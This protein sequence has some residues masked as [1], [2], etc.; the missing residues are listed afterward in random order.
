MLHYKI[1]PPSCNTP[2]QDDHPAFP[3]RIPEKR[4][5]EPDHLDR[6][7][8]VFQMEGCYLQRTTSRHRNAPEYTACDGDSLPFFNFTDRNRI[9]IDIKSPGIIPDQF[10]D[11]MDAHFLKEFFGFFSDSFQGACS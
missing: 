6:A 3:E 11:R 8:Q 5:A 7:G 9:L 1:V 2:A 4:H 10:A